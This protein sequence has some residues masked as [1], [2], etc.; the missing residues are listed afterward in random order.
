MKMIAVIVGLGQNKLGMSNVIV[1]LWNI[2]KLV[3]FKRASNDD[4]YDDNNN[5]DND[6]YDDYDDYDDDEQNENR[7]W[8]WGREKGR[9]WKKEA[10]LKL[11]VTQERLRP[12]FASSHLAI[13]CFWPFLNLRR[14]CNFFAFVFVDRPFF[15][16]VG[17]VRINITVKKGI[18]LSGRMLEIETVMETDC[19]NSW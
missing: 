7:G 18:Y 14:Y 10:A 1:L 13:N 16:S 5:N 15:I 2:T 19:N 8:G 17:L 4:D 3:S 11:K 12:S 6:D 9:S